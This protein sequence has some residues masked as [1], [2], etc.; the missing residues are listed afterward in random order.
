MKITKTLSILSIIICV[1]YLAGGFFLT[2]H[3]AEACF[4][5]GFGKYMT[6]D[7]DYMLHSFG[8]IEITPETVD[9]EHFISGTS[10]VMSV[11]IAVIGAGIA[12]FFGK[13]G[14]A[15]TIIGIISVFAIYVAEAAGRLAGAF[16][17]RDTDY[18]ST[19]YYIYN[20]VCRFWQIFA[21]CGAAL[22]ITASVY[23]LKK[24]KIKTLSIISICG[25]FLF[26]FGSMLDTHDTYFYM[27]KLPHIAAAGVLIVINILSLTKKAGRKAA[28]GAVLTVTVFP[29]ALYLFNMFLSGDYYGFMNLLCRINS[30]TVLFMPLW[31]VFG[32][33]TAASA[34]KGAY[35]EQLA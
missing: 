19:N 16:T 3:P 13:S 1:I 7:P 22:C 30:S 9:S 32:G 8:S 21:L 25:L 28:A 4:L 11:V 27:I 33:I 35:N 2:R 15:G 20:S 18:N 26:I 14:I 31:Y 24:P 17:F 10:L 34:L 23:L 6:P 29:I 12:V 5:F